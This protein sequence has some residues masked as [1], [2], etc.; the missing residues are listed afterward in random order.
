MSNFAKYYQSKF[1]QII[2][3]IIIKQFDVESVLTNREIDLVF[4]TEKMLVIWGWIFINL[5]FTLTH[6]KILNKIKNTDIAKK[7]NKKIF[8]RKW[9]QNRPTEEQTLIK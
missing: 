3:N 4:Y 5:S 6:C 9:N 2:K 8:V 7:L 1:E